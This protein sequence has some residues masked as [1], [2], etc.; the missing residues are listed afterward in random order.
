MNPDLNV[1]VL[2]MMNDDLVRVA[3]RVANGLNNFPDWEY[4]KE[5]EIEA[6]WKDV[7]PPN[8]R[9]CMILEIVQIF[10]VVNG[11]NKETKPLHLEDYSTASLSEDGFESIFELNDYLCGG[12]KVTFSAPAHERIYVGNAENFFTPI[13]RQTEVTLP[14]QN[15]TDSSHL[16]CTICAE[17]F[18]NYDITDTFIHSYVLPKF[19]KTPKE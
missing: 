14:K 12:N 11:A 13:T 18:P 15:Y 5:P 8:V 3:V 2:L 1:L 9:D 16:I 7:L 4:Y 6:K 19:R 10:D 17:L